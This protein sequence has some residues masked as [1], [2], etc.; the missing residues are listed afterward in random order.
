ML[1]LTRKG[2]VLLL[3]L[4]Y[5]DVAHLMVTA[6]KIVVRSCSLV[7]AY[8]ERFKTRRL[9]RALAFTVLVVGVQH[10]FLLEVQNCPGAGSCFVQKDRLAP[11]F[12][13]VAPFLALLV[14]LL[15]LDQGPYSLVKP[16]GFA[17]EAFLHDAHS[18]KEPL[19]VDLVTALFCLV[20]S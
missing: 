20:S 18:F 11:P 9:G 2:E 6:A 3:H 7:P 15:C 16:V 5:A 13:S 14:Q 12:Q 10:A 17:E 19:V 1:N 8:G 4:V